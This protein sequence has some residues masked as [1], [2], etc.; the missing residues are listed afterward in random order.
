MK[1]FSISPS[2]ACPK[3]SVEN[4]GQRLISIIADNEA[5]ASFSP[6]PYRAHHDGVEWCVEHSGS[7]VEASLM[8]YPICCHSEAG[9][10]NQHGVSRSIAVAQDVGNAIAT[11]SPDRGGV[12]GSSEIPLMRPHVLGDARVEIDDHGI[13]AA[14]WLDASHALLDEAR[15]PVSCWK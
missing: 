12:A 13:D 4:E 9:L 14:D 5:S 10:E 8:R 11:C 6:D 15:E 1:A 3:G 7:P 2:D